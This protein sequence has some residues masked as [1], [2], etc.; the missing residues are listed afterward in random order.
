MRKGVSKYAGIYR[1]I[2]YTNVIVKIG[3]NLRV[4]SW[5]S[6][7]TRATVFT[8]AVFV[9][10]IWALSLYVS[11]VLQADMVRLLGEQ[12]FQTVSFVAAEINGELHDRMVAL[13][14][15]AKEID[16]SA[17]GQPTLLQAI[18]EQHPVVQIMFNGGVFITGSDGTAIADVPLSNDRIG[19]NYMDRESV[20]IPLKQGKALVGRPAMGKKLGAPIFS[21]VVPIRDAAGEVIGA[22]V[23]TINLG[24][25]NFLDKLTQSQYGKAGGYLLNAPQYGLI[26]TASD[27]TRIMQPLPPMG[28]NTMLDRYMQGFEGYGISVSS[29][30]REELSSAKSI[31]VAGWFLTVVVPTEEAFAPVND[32]QRRML[33][34]TVL[35][36]LLTATL[37]WWVLTR[38]LSP[39]VATAD[40]MLALADSNHAAQPLAATR[41]DEIGQLVEG[42]NRIQALWMQREAALMD[43][44]Q[45]LAITLNSIGDA[46]MATDALGRITR[47]NPTAE[48]LTAWPLADALGHSLTDVFCIVNA[49]TGQTVTDPVQLVMA[50]GHV[51][52]LANHTVLMARDGQRYQIADSAAP[53]RNTAGVIVGVVLVFSDVTE[54]YKTAAELAATKNHLQATLDAIPD[55]LFE[56]DARGLV[57]AYH[58]HRSSLLAVLPE[59]F[60]GKNL[61]DIVPPIAAQVCMTAIQEAAVKGWTTGATYSLPLPQ[62]ETWFELSGT[63]MPVVDGHDQR[64]ILLARDITERKQSEEALRIAAT[65]FESQQ[66]MLVTNAQNVILRVNQAFTDIMGYS[67]EEVLGQTTDILSSIRH[68][69]AFYAAITQALEN[70]GVW[71]GEIWSRHKSG[72]SCPGWLSISA[73]KDEAGLTTHFVAIFTDIS[74]RLNAQAQIDTLAFYDPLTHLPNRR[75]LLDRLEQALHTST[76]HARKSALLFVD[77]DNFKTINDTQGHHQGDL[78]LTLVAQRLKTTIRDGDTVARLGSDEFVVVLEN[79]SEDDMDAATQAEVVGEK[80]LAAFVPGFTLDNGVH[81]STPSIGITLFGGETLE[82]S[83]QPLKRAELAMFQAKAAGRNTWRFFDARMQAEV[84]ARA[85]LEADLREAVRLQQFLLHYQPQVVGAGWITGVEA[86]VRWQ[87]PLRGGVSPAEFIPLAEESG[88]ILSIGQWVLETACAQLT[89]WSHQPVLSELT[90]AVNVSARQFKHSGFVDEVLATLARTGANPK[91]LKLELTESMLVD[92]VEAVIAKMGTLKARDVSFSLDDFG[93]GYSSLAYLKRLPL[94]QLKIDQGFVRNIVTDTN[95][96]AIARMVVA[97]AESMNLSVIAEG[98][99]LQAQAKFLADQGCHAYQGYLFSKPL[100]LAE[101]EA[102]VLGA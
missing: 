71:T 40:A 11:R 3:M 66:G 69:P 39:L 82:S 50:H 44:Q 94:D 53:I 89:A 97:L 75:L 51:V 45:N 28:A 21:I 72:E 57:L 8:L 98:V 26:V 96:A 34:A 42:F 9:L 90:M 12:Q 64:F 7:K 59:A 76:R 29:R 24:K 1:V 60:L 33:W 38:Q 65:A 14:V 100:P 92:D 10:G 43:S 58:A 6:L 99:E 35:L 101:L 102:F 93:T 56:V 13:D 70:K 91:R 52:G 77:L 85:A 95:D 25:P 73:V 68:D 37:T 49:T 81:H 47:M 4:S 5:Q 88:L 83:E 84:S 63:A 2:G 46:V 36:T 87:H 23:G 62:G 27:K 78:L 18:L 48:R 20:S 17:M 80:I 79:L 54:Q 22:L 19:T 74:E 31:P 55:L 15:V 32:M 67:A 61:A 41:P 30:G 86:L 16:A